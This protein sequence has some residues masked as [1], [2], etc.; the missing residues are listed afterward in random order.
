MTQ[1]LN[2][3]FIFPVV[4][5]F[6][7]HIYPQVA[8]GIENPRANDVNVKLRLLETTDLHASLVN[9]N[10]YSGKIDNRMGLVK[11]ASLIKQARKETVN[12]LLFDVGDHLQGNSL[13]GFIAWVKGIHKGQIHPVYKAFNY[14][15]YDAITIGNH[16]FNYGLGFLNKSLTGVKMPVVNANVFYARKDNPYFRPFTILKR[17]VVDNYGKQ[18]VL[19]IGVI[20]VMPPQIM[21]WD[22]EKLE[23]RLRALPM[24]SAVKKYIPIMKR[25]GADIIIVLAHTGISSDPYDPGTENAA[26]YLTQIPEVSAVLTGHSHNVFPSPSYKHL[27]NTNL[28]TGTINGKPV[29]MAGAY[30]SHLGL[31][32]LELTKHEG[33]WKV[34]KSLSTTRTIV[35]EKGNSLVKT[36]QAVYNKIKKEHMETINYLKKLGL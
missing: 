10:Y 8:Y 13:G 2:K 30:G 27:A 6:L 18:Y 3:F 15:N 21:E 11:T 36:D 24:V 7:I 14:L 35:D 25:K 34:I 28:N 23:G 19:H 1:Y 16:E 33:K 22:K 17:T 29:V 12:S 9:Y 4:L 32:D 5:L 20:G 26:Y 31:I